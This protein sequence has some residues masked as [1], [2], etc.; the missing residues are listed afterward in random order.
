MYNIDR[1]RAQAEYERTR[2]EKMPMP[3]CE[4]KAARAPQI[5]DWISQEM[6]AIEHLRELVSV[7][8]Q[9]LS[10][11]LSDGLIKGDKDKGP[12]TE[13]APLAT[14]IRNNTNSIDE[15]VESLNNIIYR[16]EL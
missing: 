16:I 11:I 10:P 1:D 8:E 2:G 3:A 15:I 7:L 12:C 9:R 5:A 14:I 13:L 6:K 4:T